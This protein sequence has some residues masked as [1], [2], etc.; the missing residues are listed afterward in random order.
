MSLDRLGV[1]G[2]NL[3]ARVS[4]AV[5]PA[6]FNIAGCIGR[7]ARG[8]T[9]TVL[10]ESVSDLDLICGTYN[11]GKYGR[12]VL[13]SFFKNLGGQSA[14]LYV[15]QYQATDAVQATATILDQSSVSTFTI[16]AGYKGIVDKSADGNL[17]GYTITNGA[18]FT[19]TTSATAISGAT[20]IVLSSVSGIRVGDIIKIISSGPVTHYAKVSAIVEATKT[21]TITALTN[22]VGSS[23][24]VTAIGFQIKTYRK[25]SRGISSLVNLPENNIWLSLE[26]ENTEFYIN[27]AFANHP[28]LILADSSSAT[29]PIQNTYPSD[30]TTATYLTIGSDGTSPT[31]SSDWNLYSSFDIYPIRYL[32]NSD[33]TLSGVNIDGE[34]YCGNRLDTPQW[35]YNIPAQQTKA[36]YI[37]IG[38]SYQRSNQVNGGI[39]AGWRNVSDPIG[40]GSNPVLR[41]PNVGA[42]VGNWIKT[43]YTLGFHRSP[44]G[45]DAPLI[46]FTD[47][48]DSTEDLFS[49]VD[50]AD[51]ANAG[52]NVC[53]KISGAGLI[54]RSFVTP[55]TATAYKFWKWNLQQNFIKISAAE[56]NS[57]AANRPNRISALKQ[58][59]ESI[60]DFGEKLF[61]GSY[62]YGIDPVNGAFGQFFKDD[63]TVSNF[64]DIFQVQVDQFNNPNSAIIAGEGSIFVYCFFSP[65]LLKL[66]IGVGILIPV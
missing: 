34:S 42:I 41:I 31:S 20:S 56:S 62:P 55:S 36:Q 58:I 30:V 32:F 28:Y 21:L 43:F 5:I 3:P 35:V 33:T 7:F 60:K 1:F 47:T 37:A 11:S 25:S 59:G 27:N 48:P 18:R 46:G 24:V 22:A 44:A 63:G 19:T 10:V 39:I 4:A 53:Q 17:T 26:S 66:G 54:L 9:S 52:M 57:N 49:D 50:V 40:V 51:L 2:Y 23:D 45:Y 13:D 6:A 8:L 29:T 38:Q 14:K 61:Q 64:E 15:K 12:Y 16:K 65:D